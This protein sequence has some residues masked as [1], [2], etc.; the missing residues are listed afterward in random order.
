MGNLGEVEVKNEIF[1][2]ILD[3]ED[4]I[5][6][7][8]ARAF[9]EVQLLLVD[10]DVGVHGA[11]H[12]LHFQVLMRDACTALTEAHNGE[13]GVV[14]GSHLVL[15]GLGQVLGGLARPT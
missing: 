5:T 12:H 11:G 1:V 3:R 9:A 15:G 14:L 7:L 6:T 4:H 13:S 10:L 8:I 2:L